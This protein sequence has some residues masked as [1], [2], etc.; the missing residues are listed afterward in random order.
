MKGYYQN[1]QA[2]REAIR[3]GWFYTG[4][5]GEIDSDGFL[6]ITDR[7]KDIIVTSGGKN[8][9]PQNIENLILQDKLFSQ[10]V[11]VGDRRNYLVALIVPNEAE[12]RPYAAS[13]NLGHLSWTELLNHPVIYE[14]IESRLASRTAG[15]AT[16]EQ[17][18]YFTLLGHELTLAAGEMTP[19]M[20]I[21]RKLVME[22]Y[23]NLIEAMYLKGE[24][25]KRTP[26]SY[27]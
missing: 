27:P 18:K 16:Y 13:R 15:L 7:K 19:T 25:K 2:T 14:W 22:K 12:V 26:A 1:E 24:E 17:I 20:K 3:D 11:V 6:K 9:S 10:I 4:D 21:K 5:I 8:I 23:K